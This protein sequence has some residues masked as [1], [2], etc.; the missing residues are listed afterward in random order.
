MSPQTND[1]YSGESKNDPVFRKSINIK[2]SVDSFKANNC[3]CVSTDIFS[4]S[5]TKE[6]QMSLSVYQLITYPLGKKLMQVTGLH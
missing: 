4:K 3:T 2:D 5:N 1:N 6:K